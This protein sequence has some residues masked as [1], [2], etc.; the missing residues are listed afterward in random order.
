V[1]AE[2]RFLRAYY[3]FEL[4]KWFGEPYEGDARFCSGDEKIPRSSVS[5]CVAFDSARLNLCFSNLSVLPAQKEEQQECSSSII[6][7]RS[8][9]IA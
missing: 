5:R 9:F 1:I 6:R 8:L 4:V 7:K 3:Q 2:A